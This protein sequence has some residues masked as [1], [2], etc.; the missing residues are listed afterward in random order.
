YPA[1]D[2][3]SLAP[4][5]TPRVVLGQR[6]RLLGVDEQQRA[7]AERET[8]VPAH[9]V[10]EVLARILGA[11]GGEAQQSIHRLVDERGQQLA[12]AAEVPLDVRPRDAG[13]LD[14]AGDAARRADVLGGQLQGS[15]EESMSTA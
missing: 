8:H 15:A 3:G 4:A 11:A 6:T 2:V 12:L 7:V 5:R 9:E 14:A 1:V 10:L 13:A